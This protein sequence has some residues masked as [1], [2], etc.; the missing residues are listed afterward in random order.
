MTAMDADEP[1]M[2][3]LKVKQVH[4]AVEFE[5]LVAADASVE[6]LKEAVDEQHS[7]PAARQRL[8]FKGAVLTDDRTL[9]GIGIVD[10]SELFLSLAAAQ[11]QAVPVATEPL[12]D[13]VSVPMLGNIDANAMRAAAESPFMR[14]VLEDPE[15]MR[16]VMFAANPELRQAV[17]RSP[18][19][20]A[21]LDDPS[22]FRQLGDA[23]RNPQLFRQM[24]QSM[25]RQMAQVSNLP[26]GEMAIQRAMSQMYDPI[27]SISRSHEA[28][29]RE[30]EE[31]L[32]ASRP[33][34]PPAGTPLPNPWAGGG[35]G[36]GA[37]GGGGGM[38][39][40]SAM[41]NLMS[42]PEIMGRLMQ[43]VGGGGMGGMGPGGFM[44]PAGFGAAPQG[45]PEVQF[46]SQLTQ[47]A[48]MGFHSREANI[49]AL[50]ASGGNVEIAL[51][52]LLGG[53]QGGP[54]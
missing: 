20:R 47:L 18:E 27:D 5:V 21:A 42:N 24:G 1:E 4:P 7:I 31:A 10:G 19:L 12:R 37:A 29:D 46:A 26:G 22:T 23:M 6:Q 39:N 41:R 34:P 9:P 50:R 44:N 8:I 14:G 17:E 53:N 13:T 48:D 3:F 16:E 32:E 35:R 2:L 15:L 45:D 54:R 36:A 38:M 51:S 25:E 33:P 30:R 52:R 49:A 11:Q 43:R 28:E 40:S